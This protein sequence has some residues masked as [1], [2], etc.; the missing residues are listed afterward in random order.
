M[1]KELNEITN[2]CD[3]MV[4]E[5]RKTI[6]E[7][8]EKQNERLKQYVNYI[9]EIMELK[10]TKKCIRIEGNGNLDEYTKQ[11]KECEQTNQQYKIWINFYNNSSL[12]DK[13]KI[14]KMIDELNVNQKVGIVG[15]MIKNR[16]KSRLIDEEII[17]I[18]IDSYQNIY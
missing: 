4:I 16:N 13:L 11:I 8:Q 3:E 10:N 5:I 7:R 15:I 17:R 9:E 2:N 14:I 1:Q 12:S 6:K 18:I